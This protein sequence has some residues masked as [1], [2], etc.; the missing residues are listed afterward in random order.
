MYRLRLFGGVVLEGPEGPVRGR[1]AQPKRLA[2]LSLLG[3]N[4]NHGWSR[5]K[6][7]TLLWPD[8]EP[9]DARHHLS[10]SIYMLRKALGD[11]A[12]TSHGEFIGLDP[13]LV[14]TDTREFGEAVVDGE[15]ARAVELYR[16]P[17]LDGFFLRGAPD[18]EEWADGERR[19][20]ADEYATAVETVA[21]DLAGK[22][23]HLAAAEAWRRLVTHDPYNSRA[24]AELM[25]CLAEAGD[26]GNA[27]VVA[28]EHADRM[29]QDLGVGPAAEVEELVEQIRDSLPARD[30]PDRPAGHASD[31]GL[32][33]RLRLALADRYD[34]ER[35]VGEGGMAT[36]F[37]ARDLKHDRE[38]AMKVL[39]PEL[40]ES[41]GN[42]RF[43]REIEI[44]ARLNHT[45]I[46]GLID[47]GEAD[48]LLYFVMPFVAG[49]SLRD[50]LEGEGQLPIE[51]AIRI[52]VEVADALG[53][54]HGL[55]IVHRDIKP[56]NILF[57]AGHAVLSDFGIARAVS[58]AK[59]AGLTRTGLSVGSPNYMSP[60]QATGADESDAR[61]DLYS[62]GCVMYEMVGGEPPYSG[63]SS[64]A[65]LSRH[66]HADIPSVSIIRPNTPPQLEAIIQKALAKA[67]AD[68]FQTAEGMRDAISGDAPI[69][70]EQPGSART[71]GSLADSSIARLAWR[72]AL[73]VLLLV[74]GAWLTFQ[75]SNSRR[76]LTAPV[77]DP[78]LVAVLPFTNA[79]G[80]P[81]LDQWSVVATSRIADGLYETGYVTVVEQATAAAEWTAVA[82][83][84]TGQPDAGW[85]RS[86]APRLG[87]GLLVTGEYYA[88]GDSIHLQARIVDAREGSVVAELG[89]FA[90]DH[91]S[92]TL[93]VDALREQVMIHVVG[94]NQLRIR[95]AD[96]P[97]SYE[98]LLEFV[99]SKRA[100]EGPSSEW[101]MEAARRHL[102][103]AIELDTLWNWPI[104]RGM[105]TAINGQ[106]YELAD[107]LRGILEA[108]KTRLQPVQ[109][110][111]Q[112]PFA[113]A[114]LAGDRLGVLQSYRNTVDSMP[115]FSTYYVAFGAQLNNRPRE[116]MAAMEHGMEG[117]DP[118]DTLPWCLHALGLHE[119]ELDT[120]RYGQMEYPDNALL[121]LREAYAL[122]GL[123]RADEAL[124]L[125][126][127]SRG[128][129]LNAESRFGLEVSLGLELK[130][131]GSPEAGQLSLE[132]GIAWFEGRPAAEQ[133]EPHYRY[134]YARALYAAG[135]WT[136]ARDEFRSLQREL[137]ADSEFF[138]RSQPDPEWPHAWHDIDLTLLGYLGTL[139]VR[140]GD[141][142]QADR[143]EEELSL[144]DRP[145]LW[146]HHDYWR[147]AIAAVRGERDQAVA[148]L[149]DALAS[150]LMWYP[151][152]PYLDFPKWA[153]HVD[154]DFESL[155]GYPPFEELTGPQD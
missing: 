39:H 72:V 16:G 57:V 41:V 98:A 126:A 11:D 155:R 106:Q 152:S 62:L 125:V 63:P 4:R 21:R 47:S 111:L 18:F 81:A 78:E 84:A 121:M 30:R 76:S 8:A 150:G 90:S 92:V 87:A 148:L 5:E 29:H 15:P 25:T 77:L 103:R 56:E 74:A 33:V 54:A 50:R 61:S 124:A 145:Y 14:W 94:P 31:Q 58:E 59:G 109:R 129:A 60:E 140:L 36:V 17:F 154:P 91:A 49:A 100:T 82:G 99:E 55:E 89:P 147:A 134:A 143:I 12:V 34:V 122:A 53:Y 10:Q 113:T 2:L 9:A 88:Q 96:L 112:L 64:V 95:H 45:N 32:L 80:D 65:V 149:A 19:R 101:D 138:L 85:I 108:R 93:A 107:S 118:W 132:R 27:L 48:G 123:T 20:L 110:V 28:E 22:G 6:L 3:A 120:A 105:V 38:V 37:L 114:F 73:A 51:D 153:F 131:H 66:L 102:L 137:E 83:S 13:D 71:A 69:A 7:A 46:L 133:Q 117:E 139:S 141:D 135:R 68:R 115:G 86:L 24:V 104:G 75:F 40:S 43:L 23:E 146:G 44:L 144:L 119:S 142:E 97:R 67:P 52:G 116:C 130:A 127:A 1:A 26:P 136:K 35:A 70:M 42:E 128:R 79:S 151:F